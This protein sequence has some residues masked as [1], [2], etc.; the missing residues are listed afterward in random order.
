MARTILAIETSCD[1]TAAAVVEDGTRVLSSV[2]KSQIARHAV[3]GGVVPE[4]ASREH[5]SMIIPVVD[6]ALRK[7]GVASRELNAVAVTYAPGLIGSLLVGV[8]FAKGLAL[9][10]NLPLIAVHHLAGHIYANQLVRPLAFPAVAL[11]VSGGH[12]ELVAVRGH[13]VFEVLGRTLDD[14]VGEAYDK[15][16]RLLDLPYPAGP[17]IDRLAQSGIPR[18]DFPRARTESPLM[19]SFSGL[20]TH[21]MHFV[22]KYRRDYPGQSLPVQDIAASFQSSVVD[23]LVDRTTRALGAVGARQLLLAGGVAAN[24]ALRR[25]LAVRAKELGVD[26]VVPPVEYCT[27]NAAMIAAYADVLYQAGR[28]AD[29]SFSPH[30][31]LDLTQVSL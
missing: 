20:K 13:G 7:A 9:A 4:I 23:V 31:T 25:A 28:F 22:Q 14:A 6:T 24:S 17:H 1:D 5:V 2:R 16:G 10:L 26:F 21:V 19:M 27:D 11:V 29:L 12:T 30:A 15:V 3:F 18:F 8:M